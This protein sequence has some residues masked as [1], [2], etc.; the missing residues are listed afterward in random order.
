MTIEAHDPNA[1]RGVWV[2]VEQEDGTAHAVSWELLGK[3]REI[4]D[5]LG[6]PLSAVVMGAGVGPLAQQAIAYGADTVY[7]AD[8]ATLGPFRLEPYAA[9]LLELV[10]ER[11][12]E[13]L[14]LGATSRGRDL[15]AA[16]A[17]ELETGLA[18]DCTGLEV[19][20]GQR[21]LKGLRP[22]FGGSIVATVVTPRQRPQVASVRPRVFAMPTADAGRSGQV[23]PVAPAMP[24][25]AIPTRVVEVL[26]EEGGVSLT[27]AK[28]IVSGGRGVGGAAGFQPLQE[29]AGLLGG[30]VGASRSAVDQQWISYPHQV[31]QTGVTVRPDLYMA[32]GISGAIQHVA[33]M[34]G[35]RYIVAI[36][37]DPE[38]PIFQVADYGIVGDIKV[39]LPAL[40]RALRE[41]MG[42]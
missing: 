27:E 22:A 2:W 16:V 19:D 29:L 28:V 1:Y 24:A 21:L 31:G 26:R 41:K 10:R 8:D 7:V 13:I 12:P 36:N 37:K 20:A 17:A 40:V 33:G 18:A 14:L 4:A 42:K 39:V 11:K 34:R 35:S 6:V 32:C 30:A 15:S 25:E 23:V 38:A 9:L 3:G 5:A